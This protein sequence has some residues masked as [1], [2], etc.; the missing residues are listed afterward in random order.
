MCPNYQVLVQT[1]SGT[2]TILPAPISATL[3]GRQKK[4]TV[5]QPGACKVDYYRLVCGVGTVIQLQAGDQFLLDGQ[6]P[7][8]PGSYAVA[9]STS[10]LQR[11]KACCPN[12]LCKNVNTQQ[13]IL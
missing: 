13:A 2:I 7:V 6:A 3:S 9:L 1:F 4:T 5:G 12:N 11:I 8:N 10:G